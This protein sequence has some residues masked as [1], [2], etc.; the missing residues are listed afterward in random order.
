MRTH[1][2][3]TLLVLLGAAGAAGATVSATDQERD[4]LGPHA[5]MVRTALR[6]AIDTALGLKDQLSLA[7]TTSLTPEILEHV[8]ATDKI[9]REL[10][11][12][13][14]GHDAELRGAIQEFPRLAQS[15]DYRQLD[16][17][18]Q[19]LKNFWQQWESQAAAPAYWMNQVKAQADLDSLL[20]QLRRVSDRDRTF[21]SNA[22]GLSFAA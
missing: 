16:T 15:R 18:F 17:D 5:I 13:A 9:L 11:A 4:S 7:E 19:S 14:N 2:L 12:T 10:L 6:A 8:Q 21:A 3:I 22:L 1:A 20:S